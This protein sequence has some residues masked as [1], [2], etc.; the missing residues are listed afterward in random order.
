MHRV[1]AK[2]NLK[3]QVPK[4]FQAQWLRAISPCSTVRGL[5]VDID[6]PE[7]LNEFSADVY[8]SVAMESDASPVVLLYQCESTS[9]FSHQLSTNGMP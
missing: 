3:R 5:I 8:H 6:I 1:D 9:D 4:F 7:S 2:E